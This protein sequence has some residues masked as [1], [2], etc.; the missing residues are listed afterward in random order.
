MVWYHNIMYTHA[1]EILADFNLVVGWSLHK[2]IKFNSP[3][4][5]P[6]IQY[7][8]YHMIDHYKHNK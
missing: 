5:F 7:T 6:A 2:T 4:T 8:Y 1:E 3:P